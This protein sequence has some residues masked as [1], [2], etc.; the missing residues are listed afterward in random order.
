MS[1]RPSFAPEP[2]KMQLG[3]A[4][5][6]KNYVKANTSVFSADGLLFARTT[7]HEE[8]CNRYVRLTVGYANGI[9]DISDYDVK[10]QINATGVVIRL[11]HR[12]D[13]V[14]ER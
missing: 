3:G 5:K 10:D 7:E 1:A 4:N 6:P 2:Q 14:E 8:C 12:L 11:G 9:K 13:P